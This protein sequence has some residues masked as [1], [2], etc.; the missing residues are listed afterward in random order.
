MIK[1]IFAISVIQCPPVPTW[2][3]S[4]VNNSESSYGTYVNVTCLDGATFEGGET[5]LVFYCSHTKEWL[6]PLEPCKGTFCIL[7][8]RSAYIYLILMQ[9]P[10]IAFSQIL[11]ISNEYEAEDHDM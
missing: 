4:A 10:F 8:P 5:A 11:F 2:E 1:I 3:S 7:S 9:L 6:P